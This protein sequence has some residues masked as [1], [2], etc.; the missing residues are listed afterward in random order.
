MSDPI[1]RLEGELAKLG[2]EHEPPP[3]WQARVLAAVAKPERA[4]RGRWWW[5]ALPALAIAAVVVIV[6]ATREPAA[7]PQLALA[8]E[9]QAGGAV[10]RGSQAKVGDVVRATATGGKH[11]AIWI[12]REDKELVAACDRTCEVTLAAPGRY[13]VV[14]L[15]AGAPLP[16]P[17]GS[18]DADL[19]A[20]LA[21]KATSRT[22]TIDVR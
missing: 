13:T 9:I 11:R 3:G 22:E 5:F 6:I 10:V 14:A 21:A 12:Y 16:Q 2:G 20:A 7:P 19:A 17:T 4:A 8:V 15:A 1:T 18:L